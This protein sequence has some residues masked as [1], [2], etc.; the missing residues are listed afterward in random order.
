MAARPPPRFMKKV[1]RNTI[2][3]PFNFYTNSGE[4]MTI[5]Q[6]NDPMIQPYNKDGLEVII[7]K[8]RPNSYIVEELEHQNE[9]ENTNLKTKIIENVED[10]NLLAGPRKLVFELPPRAKGSQRKSRRAQLKRKSRKS[11]KASR[12]H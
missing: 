1:G 8:L 6:L 12:K 4:K 10:N 11:R 3:V 9:L 7:K 5:E 2:N